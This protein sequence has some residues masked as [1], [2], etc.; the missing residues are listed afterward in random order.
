M[1][2]MCCKEDIELAGQA[3]HWSWPAAGWK[4]IEDK[5]SRQALLPSPEAK[6]PLG[7]DLHWLELLPAAS[8][9]VPLAHEMQKALPRPGCTLPASH[10]AQT[11]SVVAEE[12]YLPSGQSEHAEILEAL[13]DLPYGQRAHTDWPLSAW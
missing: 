13:L 2:P 9:K 3:K 7:Q 5:H 10:K 8:M 6:V 11:N 1:H 12:V 4:S